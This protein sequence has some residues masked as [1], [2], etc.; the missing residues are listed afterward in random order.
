MQLVELNLAQARQLI[1]SQDP[2]DLHAG[3]RMLDA[4]LKVFPDCEKAIELKARA[5]LSLRRFRDL[6]GLFHDSI[7]SLKL[8]PIFDSASSEEKVNLLPSRSRIPQPRKVWS[9]LRYSLI[10]QRRRN[11]I[12]RKGERD[13]WKYIILGQACCHLGMLEDAMRL[14]LNGKKAALAA[15][16]K[17]SGH[18]ED[19]NF[20]LDGSRMSSDT[21]TVSHL[22]GNIKLLLR[23]RTAALAALDAGL[24][25]EAARHLSKII[26]GRKGTPQGFI[27]E[28]C[29]HRALAHQ[30]AGKV[31]D[32]LAD[33]NKCLALNP[34]CAEALSLRATIYE[35]IGCLSDSFEDL[36][37]LRTLYETV[38]MSSVQWVPMQR[39]SPADLQ[40]CIDFINDRMASVVERMK[41]ESIVDHYRIL[42]LS[43][44]CSRAE[45]ECAYLILSMKHRPDK[46]AHFVD[47]CEFVDERDIEV[48]KTEARARG[49]KLFKLLQKAYTSVMTRMLEEEMNRMKYIQDGNGASTKTSED[50][51]VSKCLAEICHSKQVMQGQFLS[52]VRAM[53][54]D[55]QDQ[56]SSCATQE[57]GHQNM[58]QVV[59]G[60]T[61]EA[62][63]QVQ[64]QRFLPVDE[65]LEDFTD[66]NGKAPSQVQKQFL[67]HADKVDQDLHIESQSMALDNAW[68]S[69]MESISTTISPAT[70]LE[71]EYQE[72]QQGADKFSDLKS[73]G[74][75][76]E[77]VDT[78][79]FTQTVTCREAV[80]VSTLH[81]Q[82][83]PPEAWMGSNEWGHSVHA[84]P[85]T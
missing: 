43:R 61:G 71:H 28:C 60:I 2:A 21:D 10:P 54:N 81:S 17:Q 47:R 32:A 20:F 22:L 56:P 69:C 45:A 26:D 6:I 33:C 49:L 62:A 48:V 84:L 79:P 68:H 24:Y 5:L 55:A 66:L 40:G 25:T 8:Q 58:S 72:I 67:S 53:E 52:T 7:P 42:G 75:V 14:L 13:Q 3:I 50:G 83:L 65:V 76:G 4:T 41:R 35:M 70:S 57:A 64:N 74:N 16:R 11:R 15:L 36:G 51:F 38:F 37:S 78:T 85:V 39:S 9:S 18:L 80:N 31:V 19:D 73:Y 77:L 30:A 63:S 82:G 34:A 59:R 27:A 12:G 23:R 44:S 46:C 1:L 29:M